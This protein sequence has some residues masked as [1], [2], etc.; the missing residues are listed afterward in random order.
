MKPNMKK[1]EL[2]TKEDIWNAV[3][4]VLSDTDY[5]SEN[6]VA[7]EAF[8]LFN[9]YSDMENG[10]HENLFNYNAETIDII[11]IEK[12]LTQLTAALRNMNADEYAAILDRYGAD[13]YQ[14][15]LGLEDGQVKEAE[16]YTVFEQAD[17]AYQDLGGKINEL[18]E[19]YFV[20]IHGDLI[21]VE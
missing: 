18:L 4:A 19:D 16:Y 21:D 9:Y 3:I 1:S 15:F 10:G 17:D 8:L 5:P 13:M 7:N 20:K 6:D 11:G 2:K 12:F 14:M